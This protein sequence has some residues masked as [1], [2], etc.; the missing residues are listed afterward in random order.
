[1]WYL[2]GIVF[3]V[4]GA[5]SLP[6]SRD[7]RNDDV[8]I[9]LVILSN[10]GPVSGS[11]AAD[12]EYFEFHGIPYADSTAGSHRFKAPS[13]PPVFT[14]TFV[15]NR[16][17]IKCVRPLGV[18]F[19]GTEDC[20]VADVYTPTLD[21]ESKLPVMVWIKGTELDRDDERELSFKN[22]VTRDIVVV[23][24][25]FRES[26][27][28]YLCLGTETA[29]GNAGLKD[30][31][32]GLRWV[33]ANIEQFG[34]DPDD[35]TLLG[36]GSGAAAVDLITLSPMADGL[37]HKAISQ[38][39]IALAPWAVSRD[40][41]EYAVQVAE[42][43]GHTI[44]ADIDLSE[45][46]TRVSVSALM[47]VLNK[48]DLTD[49]SLAF[50][51]CVEREDLPDEPFLVKTPFEIISEGEFLDIP[52]ITGFVDKEGTIRA[53]EISNSNWL[54]RMDESFDAFLQADLTFEND[55]ER[56]EVAEKIKQHYFED[57]PITQNMAINYHGDT[58]ILVSA[59]RET[60]LRSSKAT[61]PIYLY[62]FSYKGTLGEP[63]AGPIEVGSAAHSEELAYLF[64]EL[65]LISET[66]EIPEMDL[67]IGDLMIER[68]TNFIKT[69][70]P[71]SDVSPV[72]WESFKN[73]A[74][75]Y[76]HIL[77][78]A[79]EEADSALESDLQDPHAEQR[80][81]WDEIYEEHFLDAQSN[82][83]VQM[84]EEDDDDDLVDS[85]STPAPDEEDDEGTTTP[86]GEDDDG[87][88]DSE[89]DDDNSASTVVGYTFM[90]IAAFA[91][92]DKFHTSQLLL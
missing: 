88:E 83:D 25:N 86:G 54:E 79:N 61:A 53:R 38:S 62:Q 7:S 78:R 90:I 6:I 56:T 17:N 49:N 4:G 50:A 23:S 46:F 34:G 31:I 92:L 20:L 14:E 27:L 58:M 69:G 73:D 85:A 28:G 74:P 32:A 15:A 43:L 12:G 65:P 55:N 64:Y 36:H 44:T 68:W 18:G 45:I 71:T 10:Q 1:M 9:P 5:L 37:V 16:K 33:Q 11:A 89:E 30:I 26:I 3:V 82:W 72:V 87:D 29:P 63:F 19:E 70:N 59:I 57:Q 67:M 41:M 66:N 13:P 80:A 91:L 81:F 39:G 24:L 52:F 8:D 76:L 77:D 2:F 60:W 48:L 75:H 35:V 84:K 21:A 40:N 42:A 47:G 51:P 22:F